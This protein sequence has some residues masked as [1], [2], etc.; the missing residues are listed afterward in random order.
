MVLKGTLVKLLT[1]VKTQKTERAR[2]TNKARYVWITKAKSWAAVVEMIIL[3]FPIL[4]QT[5]AMTLRSKKGYGVRMTRKQPIKTVSL[6]VAM[7]LNAAFT[8]PKCASSR[9]VL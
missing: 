7:P 6:A 2:A 3:E 9:R 1:A 5:S 8:V 4:S